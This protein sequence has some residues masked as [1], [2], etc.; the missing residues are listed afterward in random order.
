MAHHLR[1]LQLTRPCCVLY[2]DNVGTAIRQ[3]RIVELPGVA[4]AR[5]ATPTR[6]VRRIDPGLPFPTAANPEH[7]LTERNVACCPAFAAIPP[8]LA[9]SLREADL[10]GYNI[11]QF[12]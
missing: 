4:S 11:T 12:D 9:R 3:D 7:G 10:S 8:G 5:A 6:F 2:R 1:H